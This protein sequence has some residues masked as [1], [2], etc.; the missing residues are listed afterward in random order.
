M[1]RIV[2]A[3]VL[4]FCSVGLQAADASRI[5][6][7][8]NVRLRSAPNTSAFVVSEVPVGTELSV[9]EQKGSAEAWLHVRT[10]DGQEGWVLG[11]LTAAIDAEHYEKTIEAIVEAQ[12][13]SH[14]DIHGT[15]FAARVQLFDLI[16]RASPR[17]HEQESAARFALY[18]LRSMQDVLQGIPDGAGQHNPY[19]RWIAR[20]WD[21]IRNDSPSGLWMVAPEYTLKLHDQHRASKAA[22]DIAWFYVTAPGPGECE[23]NLPCYVGRANGAEGEYLRLQ[24]G[25]S[26]TDE[27]IANIAKFLKS[28]L[29]SSDRAA[30]DCPSF[31][32]ELQSLGAAIHASGAA[33]TQSAMVALKEIAELGAICP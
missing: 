27:A 31:R 17:V 7:G 28:L 10:D 11:R 25:G 13:K 2:V 15:S 30:V 23:G 21:D 8:T 4:V 16:E 26:H 1:V 24:P 9:L 14:M 22:D 6:I 20:H 32:E 12:L 5:T 18:R 29:G 3:V 19:D 33:R